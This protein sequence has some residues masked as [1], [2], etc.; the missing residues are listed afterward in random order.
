[1]KLPNVWGR[2][3]LFAFSGLDGECRVYSCLNATLLGDLLGVRIHAQELFDLY[4]VL[5][6]IKDI[7]F[8]VVASD[9]FSAQLKDAQGEETPVI[10]TF[11]DQQTIVG[12]CG[13]GRV[14]LRSLRAINETRTEHG[15][16]YK[17]GVS[18]FH[19]WKQD[20]GALTVFSFS[21]SSFVPVSK[22][23]INK[24]S[25][26]RIEFLERFCPLMPEDDDL[27]LTFLKSISVMKSQ[28]YTSD[29]QFRQRWTT[30]NRLPHRW[31]WLWDSVF[32]SLGNYVLDPGLA[33]DTLLSVLDVQRE[34]GFLSH[35]ARP[36]FTSDVTQPPLMAWGAYKYFER[37]KDLGFL[38]T[39]F[40]KLEK[41]L[42]WNRNNRL[43]PATGLYCWHVNT[44]SE[45]CRA[46]ESGMDNSPRFD[47][48]SSMD[49]L[50][51]CCFMANEAEAMTM[52]CKALGS[53]K[54]K[55]W[56]EYGNELKKLI[57]EYL[58]DDKDGFYYDRLPG[59][60][61]FHKVKTVAS[62]L[63]LFAGVCTETTA[64]LLAEKIRDRDTFDT[65]LP[66]PSVARNDKSFSLD[67]W[68]GA[69]WVN[70][71]YMISLGLRRYGFTLQADSLIRATVSEISRFYHSD[72]VIYEMYDPDGMISPRC[73]P[74][75]GTPIE[76]YDSRVRYQVIRDYGWSSA[77][78]AA[79]VLENPQ[80]FA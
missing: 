58:W 37:E 22:E 2:G 33:R 75:K 32:H 41:Y 63:P 12:L 47:D 34:D 62:F 36:N 11:L 9:V 17:S 45:N 1:M 42:E 57:N 48:V 46:D 38:E 7:T 20:M 66:L 80:L 69:V 68:R 31:L 50:D 79:M 35:L 71:N 52:I 44:S 55:H 40:P 76:P 74:R 43:D 39:V 53:S 4:V 61:E 5:D 24:L 29:G 14:Q 6:G 70:Y 56:R 65:R 28:V 78:F 51:F 77:L 59:R 19:F 23:L 67:M 27:G 18:S 60:G 72:G 64:P 3:A 13:R 30:P 25:E 21:Q 54:E 49:C 73:I 10:F 16:V 26:Q 8:N 15:S